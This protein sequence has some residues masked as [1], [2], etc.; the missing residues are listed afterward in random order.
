MGELS[1]IDPPRMNWPAA[2][3]PTEFASFKQYCKLVFRGPFADKD[4][5]ARVIYILLWVG[6]EGLRMY[7]T[8][9]LSDADKT[10]V[11]LIW[12]K[13]QALIEPKSN[14]RLNRFHLKKFRQNGTETP[15]EFMTRCKTQARK[16]RFRD[17]VE[18]GERLIEQLIM[19]VRHVKIQE[20]L[21]SRDDQ[22]T[23]D[24]AMDIARIH[25]SLTAH[26]TADPA[27]QYYASEL[28]A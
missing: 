2:D 24:I 16:C 22:L 12:S 15:H 10:N 1:S 25:T 23:L 21:L 28:Y 13:F 3:L 5:A 26:K 17:A 7:N 20:K 27:V 8:W 9:A 14:Y 4:D 6:R 18:T 19:G 11:D